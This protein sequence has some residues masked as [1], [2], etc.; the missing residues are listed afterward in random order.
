M[1]RERPAKRRLSD[2]ILAGRAGVRRGWWK[3]ADGAGSGQMAHCSTRPPDLR[4]PALPAPAQAQCSIVTSRDRQVAGWRAG[5]TGA[6]S[7]LPST[8]WAA[9]TRDSDVVCNHHTHTTTARQRDCSSATC[10]PRELREQSVCHRIHPRHRH[11]RPWSILP[12]LPSPT[13]PSRLGSSPG[14][15]RQPQ[16]YNAGANASTTL[17]SHAGHSQTTCLQTWQP[18]TGLRCNLQQV[19]VLHRRTASATYVIH[20]YRPAPVLL[21]SFPFDSFF[22]FTHPSSHHQSPEPMPT[23]PQCVCLLNSRLSSGLAHGS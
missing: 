11:P 18:T 17:A 6:P 21:A 7:V 8:G 20:T 3:W 9:T 22:L 5:A 23:N 16:L 1:Q 19:G 4:G 12:R 14:L 15:D 2:C 10:T 13:L